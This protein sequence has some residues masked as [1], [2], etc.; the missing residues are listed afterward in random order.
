MPDNVS[1]LAVQPGLTAVLAV[2]GAGFALTGS[3]FHALR[4]APA[5]RLARAPID[6]ELIRAHLDHV[7]P[8]PA[9]GGSAAGAPEARVL[10]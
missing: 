7:R 2:V 6:P 3:A 9:L 5:A 1:N 10:A 4:L 8:A